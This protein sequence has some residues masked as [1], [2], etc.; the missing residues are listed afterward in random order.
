VVSS[1]GVGRVLNSLLGGTGRLTVSNGELV[2][3]TP[4]PDG[5]VELS[6]PLIFS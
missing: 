2:V 3:F 6:R 1:K 5:G 4:R